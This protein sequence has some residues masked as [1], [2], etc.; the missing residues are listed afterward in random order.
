MLCELFNVL[1]LLELVTQVFV[2]IA[3]LGFGE[4]QIMG[5]I[6][7]KLFAFGLFIGAIVFFFNGKNG[8]DVL[9]DRELASSI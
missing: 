9:M 4:A 5:G 6:V 7:P 1:F 8:C 2:A 3:F